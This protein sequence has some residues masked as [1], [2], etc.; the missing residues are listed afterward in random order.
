MLP[1]IRWPCEAQEAQGWARGWH[2]V[3]HAVGLVHA[4][5][6]LGMGQQRGC[7]VHQGWTERVEAGVDRQG[8]TIRVLWVSACPPK[9]VAEGER[10][11]TSPTPTR[12]MPPPSPL[13]A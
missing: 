8:Q 13:S 2:A 1:S 9:E 10:E 4:A 5:R 12:Y 6:A 7:H 11:D 3:L